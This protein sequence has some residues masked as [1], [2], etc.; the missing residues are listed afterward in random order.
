M[1]IFQSKRYRPSSADATLA[2]RYR[3]ALA[4]HPFALFGLPFIATMV[5]GSFFLTPAT[6]LRYE[7]HDM[8]VRQ[9][10]EDERL[11]IGK[12]KRRIDMKEEY[13]KLA[14]KDLD[15]WEQKRVKRLP[16]EHDGVL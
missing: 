3:N 4:R 6:A 5:L 7:R 11:G 13:Y 15:N 1:A 12:D 9:V 2:A 14:A 8:K 10:T 16:G